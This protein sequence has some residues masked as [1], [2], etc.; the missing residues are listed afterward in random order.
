MKIRPSSKYLLVFFIVLACK[1]SAADIEILQKS[2]LQRYLDSANNDS[3]PVEKR[4]LFIVKA[5]QIVKNI[6]SD[7]LRTTYLFKIANRYWNIGEFYE[8][9]KVSMNIYNQCVLLKDSAGIVKSS[10]YLADIYKRD[11]VIDSAFFFF[12]E[13]GTIAHKIS[14]HEQHIKSM[15]GRSSLYLAH[16]DMYT[17]GKLAI[18]ALEISRDLNYHDL[19]FQAYVLLGLTSTYIGDFNQ[20]R[21]Y[22]QAAENL[23]NIHR[24]LFSTSELLMIKNNRGVLDLQEEKYD[25]ALKNFSICLDE[26]TEIDRNCE[27]FYALIA[28]AAY[29]SFKLNHPT[30]FERTLLQT[31][32]T[33][34]SMNFVS[35]RVKGRIHLSEIYQ[36]LSRKKKS[37]TYVHDAL[38]IARRSQQPNLQLLALKYNIIADSLQYKR[39]AAEYFRLNDSIQSIDSKSREKFYRIEFETDELEKANLKLR[40]EKSSLQLTSILS[41]STLVLT[42]IFIFYLYRRLQFVRSSEYVGVNQEIY[43]LMSNEGNRVETGKQM[44]KLR[45]SR[46]LHDGVMGVISQIRLRLTNEKK[47]RQDTSFSEIDKNIEDLRNVEDEIRA[48]SH[49]LIRTRLFSDSS[50]TALV[51]SLYSVLKTSSDCEFIF[52]ADDSIDWDLISIPDK[53]H[54]YRIL[55]EALQNILKH[56]SATSVELKILKEGYDL[57]ITVEDDGNGVPAKMIKGFGFYSMSKRASNLN[58]SLRAEASSKGGVKVILH[59]KNMLQ[60]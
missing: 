14:D 6:Q 41:T 46:E 16:N 25:E 39:F 50:F 33:A 43:H 47:D 13:Q 40:E 27:L 53:M 19:A 36:N 5:S 11:S 29:C 57:L 3:L 48:I 15:L 45:I 37:L 38:S 44:E 42:L 30:D 12:N 21:E 24:G 31:V 9:K 35:V 49:D 34:D 18:S 56:A 52:V 32:K 8:F 20:A 23:F 60:F 22:Y 26:K 55:Q 54:I 17:G 58:G 4:K 51:Q 2:E 59:C 1:R 28:N 7:S 10:G